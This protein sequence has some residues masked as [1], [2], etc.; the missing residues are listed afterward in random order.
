MEKEIEYLRQMVGFLMR[1]DNGVQLLVEAFQELGEE[2]SR[3]VLESIVTHVQKWQH[4]HGGSND[5]DCRYC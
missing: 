5:Q 1:E 4:E 2:P 3:H